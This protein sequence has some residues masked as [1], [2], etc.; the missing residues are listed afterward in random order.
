MTRYN[1]QDLAC[2]G[3]RTSV[4][5]LP[6]T[7]RKSQ[8]LHPTDRECTQ[9]SNCHHLSLALRYIT[10]HQLCICSWPCDSVKLDSS[11]CHALLTHG[12]GHNTITI[13]PQRLHHAN[14]HLSSYSPRELA[15]NTMWAMLSHTAAQQPIPG[16]LRPQNIVNN[17]RLGKNKLF[18]RSLKLT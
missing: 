1:L 14:N 18:D 16:V 17:R 15:T 4:M 6:D 2:T 12:R 10:K 9:A 13:P 8:H 11:G 3:H 7:L 5:R